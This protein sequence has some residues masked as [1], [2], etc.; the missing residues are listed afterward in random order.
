M[1]S[2]L[3]YYD[4]DKAMQMTSGSYRI[5]TETSTHIRVVSS[6]S[7]SYY[8][9]DVGLVGLIDPVHCCLSNVSDKNGFSCFVLDMHYNAY[10]TYDVAKIKQATL[11]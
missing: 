5:T 11:A 4:Y 10:V 6:D 7:L 9:G 1:H 3:F 2:C 8:V